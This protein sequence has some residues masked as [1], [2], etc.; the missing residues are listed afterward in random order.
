MSRRIIVVLL[1]LAGLATGC[2]G[3]K[4]KNINRDRGRPRAEEKTEV[5]PPKK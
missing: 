1:L 3:D 5:P 2:G 4:E